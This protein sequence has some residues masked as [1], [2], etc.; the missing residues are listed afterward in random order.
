MS[1]GVA[2]A[3]GCEILVCAP[4]TSPMLALAPEMAPVGMTMRIDTQL[5]SGRRPKT[6][7]R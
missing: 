3:R 2:R 4:V 7:R 6:A 5:L 1:A